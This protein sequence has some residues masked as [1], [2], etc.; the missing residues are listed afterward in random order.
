M[1]D[2]LSKLA[3]NVEAEQPWSGKESGGKGLHRWGLQNLARGPD[4]GQNE[5]GGGKV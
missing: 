1:Y 4:F 2:Y 5:R 3:S